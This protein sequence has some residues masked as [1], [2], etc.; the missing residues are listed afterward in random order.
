MWILDVS[1][2]TPEEI[3]G[4]LRPTFQLRIVSFH[5]FLA[6]GFPIGLGVGFGVDVFIRVG[7][8]AGVPGVG[9]GVRGVGCRGGVS[10]VRGVGFLAVVIGLEVGLGVGVFIVRGVRRPTS[11]DR[12]WGRIRGRRFESLRSGFP[13]GV[14][15][16]FLT[17]VFFQASSWQA[18]SEKTELRQAFSNSQF[19]DID[20]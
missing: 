1:Q 9:A 11:R 10:I 17:G 12:P 5:V 14:R 13:A 6:G 20:S 7:F 3:L 16:N 2:K 19:F 18:S 8:L 15:V 4:R